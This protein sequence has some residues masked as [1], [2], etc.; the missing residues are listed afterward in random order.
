[1]PKT[2][3]RTIADYAQIPLALGSF[4]FFR[5]VRFKMHIF[6]ALVNRLRRGQAAA[7]RVVSADMI[8]KPLTLPVFMTK[9]PRWNPHAI[10]GMVGP[11]AVKSS[12]TVRT[13]QADES[14]EMWGLVV[15]PTGRG[16]Q[17][18]VTSGGGTDV[19]WKTLRLPAG[20]YML[21]MRYYGA[22]KQVSFPAI[23]V[24]EHDQVGSKAIDPDN[25]QF[26]GSLSQR[27]NWLYIWLNY[28]V[29]TMLRFADWLPKSFVTNEYLPAGDPG[30]KYKF[31]AMRRNTALRIDARSELLADYAIYFTHY[32]RASFPVA[33][34]EIS[35]SECTVGDAKED[36]YYLIRLLARKGS[37]NLNI[38]EFMAVTR[39]A[40]P[41]VERPPP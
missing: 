25:N 13:G 20:H 27:M 17:E 32:N 14:A 18:R 28:Y 35:S 4:V 6:V 9:A 38:D 16:R 29:F 21:V 10:I 40:A 15:Q 26:Y 7:W 33:S 1:M 34:Q 30:M 11:L 8:G 22:G 2:A 36:G 19:P 39:V 23:R 12:I 3:S 31:G 37:S 41:G 5:L 24:D